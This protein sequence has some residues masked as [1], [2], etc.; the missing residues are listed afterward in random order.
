MSILQHI[1]AHCP[2]RFIIVM[3]HRLHRY[4]HPTSKNNRQ[5]IDISTREYVDTKTITLTCFAKVTGAE[6]G[7]DNVI[8]Y[9]IV[10]GLS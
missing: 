9:A 7:A 1:N 8:H 3:H 5:C 2:R 10:Q 4:L 6:T